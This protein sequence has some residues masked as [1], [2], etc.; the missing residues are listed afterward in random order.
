MGVGLLSSWRFGS[1][2]RTDRPK[3]L[4]AIAACRLYRAPLVIATLDR[5]ARHAIFLLSLLDSGIEFIA[6]DMPD[7]DRPI[8]S[9][10]A[11]VADAESQRISERTKAALAAAKARGV[12]LGGSHGYIP[13]DQDRAKS[14]AAKRRKALISAGPVLAEIAKLRTAGITKPHAIAKALNAR[15]ISAPRGGI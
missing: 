2:R 9:I 4:E 8:I 13:T 11:V 12:I 14:A 15:G 5:V 3:L 10:L 1:G 7:A 6:V